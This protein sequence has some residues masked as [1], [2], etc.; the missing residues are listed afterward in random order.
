MKKKILIIED[1]IQIGSLEEEVLN[2]NGYQCFRAYSGSEAVLLLEKESIDLIILDL[3]L[4]G[5]SEEVLKKSGDIPVIVVS[6]KADINDKVKIL[7]NGAQDYMT[8]PFSARE[9]LAR[10]EV[11]LRRLNDN[12]SDRYTDGDIT[13]DNI[14]HSVMV[15]NQTVSLTKT[16][17]AILKL[18]PKNSGKVIA[19]SVILENIG[20]NYPIEASITTH[21]I[22]IFTRTRIILSKRRSV[23]YLRKMIS[24]HNRY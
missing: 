5:L 1:D 13:M 16:E 11:Q 10:V 4:T 8:K 18:L 17:Y 6:A 20:T 7:K 14:S 19:K 21:N 3:M 22:C 2:N 24:K 9:P 12:L 15:K 23:F